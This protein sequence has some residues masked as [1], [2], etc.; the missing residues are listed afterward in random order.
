MPPPAAAA[1]GQASAVSV[2]AILRLALPSSAVFLMATIMG[3]VM[4]RFA[5]ALGPD[6]VAAVNA[7]TR[8]YNVFIAL[9][10]GI[11]AGTLALVSNAWGAGQREEAARLL[12]LSLLMALALGALLSLLSAAGVPALIDAFGLDAEARDEAVAYARWL[13]TFFA[14]MAY[15]LILSAGLRSAGDVRT[16]VLLALLIN[17]GWLLLAWRWSTHP[18]LGLEP[19]VRWIALGM[20]LGHVPGA[21]AAYLLWKRGSLVLGPVAPDK[22]DGRR[23]RALLYTGYPSALEQ[24][25]L[26]FGVVAF[27]GITGRYGTA[28]F[29]AYGTGISLLSLAMV[30]GVGFSM[31]VSVMVGQQLG[32]GSPENA[33]LAALRALKLC[34]VVLGAPGLVLALNARPVALWLTGD[35]E[36]A[37]LTAVA[38]YAFTAVLPM[39]AVEFCIGGALRGAGDT[40]F[41]LLNV[42]AGLFV[43]RFGLAFLLSRAGFSIEWIYATLVADYSVKSSLLMWRFR[44]GRWTHARVRKK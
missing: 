9:C 40:R 35:A 11:S 16:P 12:Q 1:G 30:V 27:I 36:I 4:I 14:P 33:R 28:A 41:P 29:A 25:L 42:L 38:I 43:V 3:L 20:G 34:V 44:S 2:G 6:A 10:A 15:C 31:A 17:V 39:L 23:L 13:S 37:R 8:L 22:G 24:A 21:A 26:Q 7:G 32:A 19:H 5:S 18:P